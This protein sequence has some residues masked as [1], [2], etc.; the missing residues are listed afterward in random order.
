MDDPTNVLDMEFCREAR[1]IIE[2]ETDPNYIFGPT[3]WRAQHAQE[4]EQIYA[5]SRALRH[6]RVLDWLPI[7]FAENVPRFKVSDIMPWTTQYLLS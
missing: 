2:A 5:E 3:E 7:R 6:V 1:P 4:L